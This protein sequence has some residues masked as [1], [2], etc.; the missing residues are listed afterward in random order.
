VSSIYLSLINKI[1]QVELCS[2]ISVLSNDNVSALLICDENF[3]NLQQVNDN[4]RSKGVKMIACS[5]RGVCG[6]IF[7]DF[8]DKFSYYPSYQYDTA[9]EVHT[10]HKLSASNIYI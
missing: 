4:C 3:E 1:V 5:V 9:Q 10:R 2:D 7:S 6:Y 8:L